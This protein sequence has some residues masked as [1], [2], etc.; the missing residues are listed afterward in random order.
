MAGC[1]P[2]LPGAV[3][4]HLNRVIGV[5]GFRGA[6]GIEVGRQ[7]F[8][9]VGRAIG[10]YQD[11]HIA[12]VADVLGIERFYA[13]GYSMGG[14][15]AQLLW[16]RHAQR[17]DGLV[18][19]ATAARFSSTEMRRLSFLASPGLRLFG[20]I[21]PRDVIRQRA[22]DWISEQIEDPEMRARIL[23]EVAQSDPVTIGQAASAVL[24]FDSRDWIEQVDVPASIVL[25]QRDRLVRPAAQQAL[26]DRLHDARVFPVDGEHSACRTAPEAFVP[27]LTKA[28]ASVVER[29]RKRASAD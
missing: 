7:A 18:L 4:R 14:P 19:C 16:Q 6:N 22:L 5:G 26:A 8:G 20:R 11:Q 27:A 10:V 23:T 29:A 1:L 24:R 12:L 2:A 13:A 3:P 15:I 17:V 9:H 28:C 25:T 21:A